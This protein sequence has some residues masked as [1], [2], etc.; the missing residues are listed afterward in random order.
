MRILVLAD[1]HGDAFSCRMAIEKHP[2]AEVVVHLGDG[3]EDLDALQQQLERHMV[4]CV[5]GNT[6]GSVAHGSP[7]KL[8]L[9]LEG[10]RVY[11][12][13]G[14]AE[15]VKF[16]LDGL[17]AA[18]GEAGAEVALYGHTHRQ[19]STYLKG[20]HVLNPGSIKHGEYALLD[21]TQAGIVAILQK[22]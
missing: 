4:Y 7:E 1:S 13:H 17:L 18:A 21:I 15:K 20:L 10:T 8:C 16:G 6:W 12:C 9:E 11:L 5:R 14:Y 19:Y 22:L 3:E 2:E